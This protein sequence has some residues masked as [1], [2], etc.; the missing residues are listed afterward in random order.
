MCLKLAYRHP[1]SL[2][3]LLTKALTSFA[4]SSGFGCFFFSL[5]ALS[6]W[7][8]FSP[9]NYS[10]G[11]HLPCSGIAQ[12]DNLLL[13]VLRNHGLLLGH[14]QWL[15]ASITASIQPLEPILPLN[16]LLPK[17][18]FSPC[19]SPEGDHC[20][21]GPVNTTAS[22]QSE[23]QIKGIMTIKVNNPPLSW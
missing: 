4:S 16:L 8:P 6:F 2:Q 19:S 21:S 23:P 13:I 20:F 17:A 14:S 1:A 12:P 22:Y 9:L 18:C 7:G 15:T 10:L 3:V 5:S 11:E